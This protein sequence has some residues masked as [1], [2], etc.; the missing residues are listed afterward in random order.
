MFTRIQG[1]EKE[2]MFG[3]GEAFKYSLLKKRAPSTF[4]NNEKTVL[5]G[6]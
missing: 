6:F 2:S 5:R 3:K 1:G 4:F